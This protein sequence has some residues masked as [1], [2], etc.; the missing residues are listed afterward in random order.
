MNHVL[1][2]IDLL[3]KHGF[4]NYLPKLLKKDPESVW[5]FTEK[6]YSEI[7]EVITS[8]LKDFK[9]ELLP[10]LIS[11]DPRILFLKPEKL[12]KK[13]PELQK[14]FSQSNDTDFAL[15]IINYPTL[16]HY[17]P[18]KIEEKKRELLRIGFSHSDLLTYL[19]N[20]LVRLDIKL[21][22]LPKTLFW[23]QEL[24]RD[25]SSL[26]KAVAWCHL[27]LRDRILPRY[28]YMRT[29][30]YS[31]FICINHFTCGDT[32]FV[33]KMKL[34]AIDF[35]KFQN[36]KRG[37]LDSQAALWKEEAHNYLSDPSRDQK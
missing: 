32:A 13:I 35:V 18:E 24:R 6:N 17:T 20:G 14:L 29:I 31:N 28:H 7:G 21:N 15:L 3:K 4:S 34:K 37:Y 22:L 25:R 27:S 12:R 2:K 10:Q 5:Y 23:V 30:D 16:L 33:S 26:M 1:D 11:K 8:C 19:Q 9:K 36:E